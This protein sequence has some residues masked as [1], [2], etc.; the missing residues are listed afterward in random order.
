MQIIL[1]PEVIF[2]VGVGDFPVCRSKDY[3]K[4]GIE[5]YLFEPNKIYYDEL[6]KVSKEYKNV[7][8]FDCAITEDNKKYDFWSC[9]ETSFLNGINAPVI[10]KERF[11]LKNIKQIQVEGKKI[12]EFDKG[13]IDFLFLDTEGAEWFCLKH[14]ISRP[15]IVVIETHGEN[16]INPYIH[17]INAWILKNQYSI[18]ATNDSDSFFIRNDYLGCLFLDSKLNLLY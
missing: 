10:K 12:S 18:M 11:L 15:K 16:Y 14:L 5:C 8:L 6:C 17:Q 3:W 7:K 13:N 4:Y 1:K 9:G 2:E